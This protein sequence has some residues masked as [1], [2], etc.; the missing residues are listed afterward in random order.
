MKMNWI[1]TTVAL[2]VLVVLVCPASGQ[3][4]PGNRGTA[5]PTQASWEW[6]PAATAFTPE[7]DFR[8]DLFSP[9]WERVFERN[10]EANPTS[11]TQFFAPIQEQLPLDAPLDQ[12]VSAS[13]LIVRGRLSHAET[14]FYIHEPGTLFTLIPSQVL[15]GGRR[16]AERTRL[17]MFIPEATIQTPKGYICSQAPPPPLGQVPIPVVGD[18]VLAFVSRP[19]VNIAG[20]I[21]RVDTWTQL[22]VKRG[23][24][25]LA[26]ASIEPLT[27]GVRTPYRSLDGLAFEIE[28]NPGV[29]D[30]QNGHER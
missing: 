7:G 8:P 13:W 10:R 9:T 17:F 11:C 20:N 19:A 26:P 3:P 2:A 14:G 6:I 18:E 16:I 28:R 5:R 29:L 4:V 15:K 30:S 1:R 22:V 27:D 23:T 12:V 24:S 25:V 21:L